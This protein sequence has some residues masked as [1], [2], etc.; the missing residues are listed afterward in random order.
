MAKIRI[1][2]I[3]LILKLQN[4]APPQKIA[5]F[6]KKIP[7]CR[8]HIHN[9]TCACLTTP[10]TPE[11]NVI[12][13]LLQK[14]LD[15]FPDSLKQ[16]SLVKKELRQSGKLSKRQ[17]RRFIKKNLT[18][19]IYDNHSQAYNKAGCKGKTANYRA[20]KLVTTHKIKNPNMVWLSIKCF[21]SCTD[22]VC[23]W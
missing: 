17:Y 3:G 12:R 8:K 7:G 21:G 18:K 15:S 20:W 4:T 9:A 16:V 10:N 19:S 14:Q 6:I 22:C 13:Y 11:A 23:R 2:L 1:L 5:N